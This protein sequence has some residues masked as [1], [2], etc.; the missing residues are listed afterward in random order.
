VRAAN[1]TVLSLLV[2]ACVVGPDYVA[3]TRQAPGSFSEAPANKPADG[4]QPHDYG[5]RTRPI[6]DAW[7]KVLG[8]PVLEGLLEKALT[9]APSIA[10]AQARV[11]ARGFSRCGDGARL[12]REREST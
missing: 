8:D 9:S 11:R 3:P 7:W 12:L 1:L 4:A 5:A 10:E 6:D 2:T